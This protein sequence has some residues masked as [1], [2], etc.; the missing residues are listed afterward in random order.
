MITDKCTYGRRLCLRIC[1]GVDKT[2]MGGKIYTVY[3][4]ILYDVIYCYLTLA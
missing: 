1:I 3:L 4:Y 2:F